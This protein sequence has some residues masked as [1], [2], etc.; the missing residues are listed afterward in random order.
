[1]EAMGS[2]ISGLGSGI[3][4]SSLVA[5]L[6]QAERAPEAQMNALKLAG[7][8]AQSAWADIST[9][10][11]TLKGAAA[12]LDTLVKAQG[13][14]ATS[15]DS[16]VLTATASQGAQLGQ[17]A[18]RVNRLASAQLV[19]SGP[20]ASPS[21]L[22][23][24]GRAVISSGLAAVGAS[25]VTVNGSATPGNHRLVVT[26]ASTAATAIGRGAPALSYAAPG[27]DLSVTLLDGVAHNVTLGSYATADALVAD[28]NSQLGGAATASMVAGQLH[29]TSRDQGSAASLSLAGGA[30]GALGLST[31]TSG[32]DALISVDGGDPTAVSHLDRA[33]DVVLP[34][35]FTL[36]ATG[37]LSKGTVSTSVISTDETTTLTQLGAMLTTSGSPVSAS[38]LDTGDSSANPNRFVL[39]AVQTGSAGALT[40]DSSGIN[41]LGSGQ[42]TTVTAAADA[43]L[44]MGGATI[45][46]TSNTISDLLPGVTLNLVKATAV[47]APA[48][49]VTVSRDLP[50]TTKNV[51]ALVDGLN[52]VISSVKT[53]TA[54]NATTKKGGPLSGDGG[55]RG[56]PDS[57]L[58]LAAG[59]AGTGLTKVLSQMGIQTTRDGTLTFDSAALGTA[60]A[61]DPDGVATLLSTFATSVESF[62]KNALGVGG[63][64][65]T[66][67][68]SAGKEIK[69]RQDQIDAFE[70]R[71]RI[72]NTAYTAK[73]AALDAMLGTLKAKQSQLASQISSL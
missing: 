35:G 36:T 38:V 3:D 60:M 16:T 73:F 17:I 40:I 70:I 9:K 58:D 53:Q 5:Q 49:S 34:G 54:Y 44:V 32:G 62:S 11:T 27:N 43:Q 50:G 47:D 61:S 46:R 1:M 8:S 55:A 30:L 24:A 72:L 42:L 37:P 20:L 57:I 65:T 25:R 51:Q 6:M 19:T 48:T 31:S 14:A 63:V 64:V 10:T 68:S 22:V 7:L 28:L 71:M 18:I 66:G 15:S 41:V 39:S 12:A 33:T 67:T 13:A 52:A 45:T 4:M 59:A 56:I 26:Q 69:A 2:T 29:L 21:M 23:G